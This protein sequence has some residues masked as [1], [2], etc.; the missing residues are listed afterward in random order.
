MSTTGGSM[1]DQSASIE[2]FVLANDGTFPNNPL[3]IILYPSAIQPDDHDPAAAFEGRFRENGW[4]ETWRN[5]IFDYH[6]YHAGAHE[7]LG[8]ARGRV[9]VMLGGPNGREVT[10]SAG[11]VVLLPA[12]TAH[13]NLE[14]SPDYLIVGAY[15]PGQHPDMKYGEPEEYEAAREE[16][17]RVPLPETDPVSRA[18]GT[19]REQ[20]S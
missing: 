1:S 18:T 15:P 2:T 10:L 16:I 14:H 13:R 20:W 19:I 17:R 5:G 7:V 12:G 11:D 4:S 8:C 6:H 9:R 3:P